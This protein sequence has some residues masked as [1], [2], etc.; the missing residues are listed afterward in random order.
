MYKYINS[1]VGRYVHSTVHWQ[2]LTDIKQILTNIVSFYK[3]GHFS[4]KHVVFHS[5]NLGCG[6]LGALTLQ[7]RSFFR[8]AF[9]ISRISFGEFGLW[10]TRCTDLPPICI[11]MHPYASICTR[12]HPYALFTLPNANIQHTFSPKKSKSQKLYKNHNSQMCSGA[13]NRSKSNPLTQI[14]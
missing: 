5:E 9:R 1:T 13:Q 7:E 11:R 14:W 4:E 8:K 3:N 2:I 12:M 6:R 10:A